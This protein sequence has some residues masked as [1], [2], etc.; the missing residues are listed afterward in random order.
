MFLSNP[1]LNFFIAILVLF[2]LIIILTI[3]INSY[4]IKLI[5]SEIEL[6][7]HENK[8]IFEKSKNKLYDCII[9]TEKNTFLIKV[10][11]IPSN[12]SVT[13]N[14]KETWCLRFG[15]GSRNGRNYPN[16]QYMNDLCDFLKMPTENTKDSKIV[17][18]I[19]LYPS[20]E[21][22]LKYMNESEICEIKPSDT[23][24]GYKVIGY[25]NLYKDFNILNK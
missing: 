20:T 2:V 13:I 17:K 16:K 1:F 5:Y 3:I 22:I 25:N 4:K 23:P 10:T 9:K 7:A 8:F 15:G 21:K 14:S 6:F 11:K 12:S 18:L 24:Y 19:I